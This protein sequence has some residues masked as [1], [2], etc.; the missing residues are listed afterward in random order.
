MCL[1]K[2]KGVDNNS[3]DNRCD[4]A[5]RNRYIYSNVVIIVVKFCRNKPKENTLLE[6]AEAE[7]D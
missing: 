4:F 2:F 3:G 7:D 6:D 1:N 5:D